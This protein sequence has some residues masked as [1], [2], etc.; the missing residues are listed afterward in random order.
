MG[1]AT[2]DWRFDWGLWRRRG[3]E[4]E[5]SRGTG[6]ELRS[7][8]DST[9]MDWEQELIDAGVSPHWAPRLATRLEGLDGEFGQDSRAALLRAATV[10]VEV[11]SDVQADVER[12][13]RDVREVERLLGAFTGELEKLDEVLNVLGAYAQRMRS[14]PVKRARQT[15]H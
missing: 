14:Q 8:E 4:Q 15:L 2:M 11:Q 12:N 10:A 1:Y 7:V 5:R 6:S 9:A 13:L 3:E